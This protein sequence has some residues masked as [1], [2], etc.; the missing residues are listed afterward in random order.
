V[1]VPRWLLVAEDNEDDYILVRRA[2]R[3]TAP[4]LRVVRAQDG[5]EAVDLLESSDTRPILVLTD[6]KMPR[7]SG[8]E[9]LAHVRSDPHLAPIPTMVLTS[10]DEASDV[11][12]AYRLGCNAYAV[13]PVDFN[14]FM[15]EMETIVGFW[16]Q[17]RTPAP[18]PPEPEQEAS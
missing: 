7:M 16:L 4:D 18:H 2:V 10:S 17:V 11:A 3:K 1:E 8:L 9:V 6:L 14:E 15:T 5:Q 12:E 13:K